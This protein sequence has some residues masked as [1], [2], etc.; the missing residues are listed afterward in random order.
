MIDPRLTD[1]AAVYGIDERGVRRLLHFIDAARYHLALPDVPLDDRK[2]VI[3]NAV[4]RVTQRIACTGGRGNVRDLGRR[5]SHEA[6]K[7]MS[8]IAANALHPTPGARRTAWRKAVTEEHQ[9]RVDAIRLW[10]EETNPGSSEILAR[11]LATPSAIITMAENRNL[12]AGGW[13]KAGTADERYNAVGI[14]VGIAPQSARSC[15]GFKPQRP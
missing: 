4:R 15:F 3:D 8:D 11:L 6:M 1:A 7:V 2:V 13:K 10:W 14:L 5:M 12:D 9:D